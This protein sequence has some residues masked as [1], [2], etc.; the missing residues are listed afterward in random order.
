MTKTII[1]LMLLAVTAVA[2]FPYHENTGNFNATTNATGDFNAF[3]WQWM[4]YDDQ[5]VNVNLLPSGYAMVYMR[6]CWP[7]RGTIFL[8]VTD[9][10]LATTNF[11]ASITRS[12]LPPNGVYYT[13]FIGF[14]TTSTSSVARSLATGMINIQHSLFENTTQSTWTNPAA[15]TVIGPPIHTLSSL[16]LWPFVQT[17][18]MGAGATWTGSNYTFAAG[19]DDTSWRASTQTWNTVTDKVDTATL[20][21]YVQTNN[22]ALTDNRTDGA[23]VHTNDSTYTQ[24]VALAGGAAQTCGIV[25]NL[26]S[27]LWVEDGGALTGQ[28]ATLVVSSKLFLTVSAPILSFSY[29]SDGAS[30]G[31]S[32]TDEYNCGGVWTNLN[33][34][35]CYTARVTCASFLPGG[36]SVAISNVAATTWGVLANKGVTNDLR[37]TVVN[38]STPTVAANPATKAYVDSGLAAITPANWA[39]YPAVNNLQMNGHLILNSGWS[40]TQTSGVGIISYGDVWASTNNMTLAHNGTPIITLSSGYSG[41]NILSFSITGAT[42]AVMLVNTNGVVSTPIIE[43]TTDLVLPNWQVVSATTGYPVQTNGSYSYSFAVSAG[44]FYRAVQLSG[45]NTVTISGAL[46]ADGSNLTGITAEQ[47]GALATNGNNSTLVNGAGY[48]VTNTVIRGGGFW[49][50]SESGVTSVLYHVTSGNHTN[51]VGTYY[52]E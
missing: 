36:T 21:G 33:I 26:I 17:N 35:P 10:V 45:T 34:Y 18:Q 14:E 3:S 44:A 27:G 13:E 24:T 43:T 2:D 30:S 6:M 41:L 42:N 22:P 47:V 12:N 16:S 50:M 1:T 40:L 4:G 7:R 5:R 51:Q 23:A 31:A 37:E 9:G 20:G 29:S 48:L 52:S 15:G 49:L 25:S 8:E 11:T 28:T 19:A 46:I 32:L 39:N 38:V